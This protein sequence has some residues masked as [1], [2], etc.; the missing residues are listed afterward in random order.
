MRS[1]LPLLLA[2]LLPGQTYDLVLKGGH[3]VD[4]KNRVDAVADVAIAGNRIARIAPSIPSSNAKRTADVSGLYVTPGLVDIHVHVYAG[5][6][7]AGV[8]TGDSSVYPDGFTF[9]SGVTTVAD[10]GTSGWRNFPDFKQRVIDRA[11]TRVLALINIAGLGMQGSNEGDTKD[12]DPEPVARLAK[13]HPEVVVGVKTA[14]YPHADWTSVENA[15]KAG[16][17]ADI[18]VM[19]DFG[20]NKPERPIEKLFAEKLRPG[21]IYTHAFSGL[22]NELLPDG[23]INPALFAARKRG[24]FFDIGHGSGSFN[25]NVASAAFRQNFPPD[26]ISSDLHT[27]S[28]NGGMKDMANIMSKVSSEGVPLVEV[29]RMATANPAREI[30]RPQYGSLGEGGEAD[31]AVFRLESGQFGYLDSRGV[32]KTGSK[33]LTCEMTLRAG[34]V[35]W[36]LNGRASEDWKTYYRETKSR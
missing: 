36:D 13:Q 27:G 26:S 6:G 2:S 17:M 11:Q 5:T 28:M 24:I 10:A 4:P 3:V 35:V 1:I 29:I 14:H 16:T 22:R 34:R 20:A 7:M 15:V 21:D 9:R 33:R 32:R 25:W 19:V 23:N 18:P 30:K 12:L 8:L 31:I